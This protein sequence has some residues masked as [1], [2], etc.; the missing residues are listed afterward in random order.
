[1][2]QSSPI[3]CALGGSRHT[4]FRVDI[5]RWAVREHHS[6]THVWVSP[7]VL[8]IQYLD[9]KTQRSQGGGCTL[10]L[11]YLLPM[12]GH[13]SAVM[14]GAQRKCLDS[15][16]LREGGNVS[17]GRVVSSIAPAHAER[18]VCYAWL[19]GLLLFE[20][21]VRALTEARTRNRITNSLGR[22]HGRPPL[23]P[24]CS[25]ALFPSTLMFAG[26]GGGP[27]W[28]PPRCSCSVSCACP[29]S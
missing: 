2:F 11:R 22:S 14:H 1:M 23:Q 24:H 20:T 25:P 8:W 28:N 17:T 27:W 19:H 4:R 21:A 26:V 16:S 3:A 6:V 15:G 5:V 9:P 12:G 13:C 7:L 18:N 29:L 10:A